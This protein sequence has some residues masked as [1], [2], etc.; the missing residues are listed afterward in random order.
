MNN[1]GILR[2]MNIIINTLIAFALLVIGLYAYTV[3]SLFITAQI[4]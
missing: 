3:Y 2:R 4:P 1:H